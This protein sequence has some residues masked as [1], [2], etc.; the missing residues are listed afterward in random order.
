MESMH[1]FKLR[2]FLISYFQ[3]RHCVF[4]A[5]GAHCQLSLSHLQ[6][7]IDLP[8]RE[9][10][11]RGRTLSDGEELPV[12]R[13]C[14]LEPRRLFIYSSKDS[15]MWGW[16]G[17][18]LAL[19]WILSAGRQSQAPTCDGGFAQSRPRLCLQHYFMLRSPPR[20]L[21][22][23]VL[24][25]LYIPVTPLSPPTS[26]QSLSQIL[27]QLI[28]TSER[29]VFRSSSR[30]QK[31]ECCFFGL[32]DLLREFLCSVKSAYISASSRWRKIAACF[33]AAQP[34][35]VIWNS[36]PQFGIA[37]NTVFTNCVEIYPKRAGCANGAAT[38]DD[39]ASL[40]IVYER[41]LNL[42]WRYYKRF[43]DFIISKEVWDY[44]PLGLISR[45]RH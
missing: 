38:K 3:T 21:C 44:R 10:P 9:P 8:D 30:E 29:S 43:L 45:K 28:A 31:M 33:K 11:A 4:T 18:R 15:L 17:R 2:S 14:H 1:I 40:S 16:R 26:C 34:V 24:T 22:Y 13:V 5:A 32:R 20:S 6:I 27:T 41:K 19:C 23:N 37:A 25:E 42:I 35:D 39:V 7:E 12:R 36:S